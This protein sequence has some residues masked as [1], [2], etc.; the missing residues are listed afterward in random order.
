MAREARLPFGVRTRWARPRAAL[1]AYEWARDQGR[2]PSD[3][4]HQS[5]F[6]AYFVDLANIGDVDVLAGRAAECALD[7]NSLRRALAEGRFRDAVQTQIDEARDLQITAVPAFLAGDYAVVGAQPVGVPRRL[8]VA[9]R[10]GPRGGGVLDG[11][12]G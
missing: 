2:E 3:R 8:V 12:G 7:G 1:E 11:Q 5:V 6:R 4:L 9:A 10:D